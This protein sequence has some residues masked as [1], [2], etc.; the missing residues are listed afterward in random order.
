[1]TAPRPMDGLLVLD[2]TAMIAGPLAGTI[3][4]DLGADVIKVEPPSGDGSRAYFSAD[5]TVRFSSMTAAFNRGKRG[6]CVD[7]T[8]DDDLALFKRIAAKADVILEG[9]RPGVAARLGIAYDDIKAINDDIIYVSI[10]GFGQR[11][12]GASR[13]GFDSAVQGE[14]GL[15]HITGEPDAPP[16]RVGTQVI[17][18]ATGHVAAQATLAALL[19]RER[20]GV[21]DYIDCSLLTTAISLQ[22]HNYCEYLTVDVP[23]SR[24]GSHPMFIT[25]SGTYETSDGALTFSATMPKHWDAFTRA[26]EDP[27]LID[28]PKYAEQDGRVADREFLIDRITQ[29]MRTRTTADW[30]ERFR[31]AGIVYG[32]VRDYPTVVDSDQFVAN[33]MLREVER[34]GVVTRTVRTPAW[35]S[36]FEYRS[37]PGAPSL[38]QDTETIAAEFPAQ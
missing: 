30:V 18:T 13:P 17:D 31:T 36:S 27:E 16:Q 24:A 20:H 8:K 33:E 26:L 5:P 6:L 28:N 21:G 3:C 4:A 19:N 34:D 2:L 38:G 15:M 14:S 7:L 10:S 22:T 23:T 9:F 32:E 25:P 12:P 1:M 37:T 11:G 35:Y 29:I